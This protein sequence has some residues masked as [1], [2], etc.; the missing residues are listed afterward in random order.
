MLPQPV[1][2]ASSLR[3]CGTNRRSEDEARL[4]LPPYFPQRRSNAFR[5]LP[6]LFR[7]RI[8]DAWIVCLK[9]KAAEPGGPDIPQVVQGDGGAA[10]RGHGHEIF[11]PIGGSGFHRLSPP[12][13]GIRAAG[14]A[15]H[16]RPVFA[17]IVEPDLVL[18]ARRHFICPGGDRFQQGDRLARGFRGGLPMRVGGDVA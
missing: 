8:A 11:K 2:V 7:S 14:A 15:L 4:N 10:A 18:E 1:N 5:Y 13:L 9:G 3:R 16:A 6:I 17:G 12:F